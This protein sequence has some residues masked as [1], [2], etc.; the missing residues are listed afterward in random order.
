MLENSF[1]Y[2]GNTLSMRAVVLRFK[3]ETLST[4]KYL[5][6]ES[7]RSANSFS[8]GT[9]DSEYLPKRI[10]SAMIKESLASVYIPRRA[11]GC[12]GLNT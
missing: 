11:S 9:L 7:S 6:L 5:F 8:C 12:I 4:M 10:T 1:S 3:S 2:S